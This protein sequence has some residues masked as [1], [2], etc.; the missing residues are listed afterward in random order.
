MNKAFDIIASIEELVEEGIKEGGDSISALGDLRDIAKAIDAGIEK[1]DALAIE[2]AAGREK[3]FEHHG[4]RWTRLEGSKR[5]NYKGIPA[6][7]RIKEE[8]GEEEHK[9]QRAYE[10]AQKVGMPGSP[11]KMID[12]CVCNVE[13][14][15][16]FG[17]PAKATFSKPQLRLEK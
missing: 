12:G 8:L 1:V 5:M 4:R 13:T 14:G 3:S 10:L 17:P 15:E 6:W 16:N 11:F 9:A 2:Q 7:E